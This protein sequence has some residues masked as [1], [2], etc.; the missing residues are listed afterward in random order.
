MGPG[1]SYSR[2]E[3]IFAGIDAPFAFVDLDA[4][5]SNAEFMLARRNGKPIRVAS[6][7][8]RCR[9]ILERILARDEGFA[10]V[11]SFTLPEALFLAEAG[12]RDLLVAY[13]TADRSA[14]GRLASLAAE[15]PDRAPLLTVD[16]SAQL[17][18][19]E[20]AVADGPAAIRVCIDLDLSWRPMGRRAVAIGPKR[21]PIRTPEAAAQLAREIVDR[22]GLRLEGVMAYEGQIA[23]VGDAVPGKPLRNTLTRGMQRA[24]AA[25]IRSRR[26]AMVSAIRKVAEL[27]F[28]NGGGTGS[29]EATAAEDAVSELSAGSGFYAP[30]L[31]DH[32]RSL[33]L[34]PAAVFTLPI[35]RRPDAGVGTAL[36][37]GYVASGAPGRDG[38]PSPYLPEGL[39]LDRHEGAGE[40]QTP[41]V[42]PGAGALRVG[43]RV[44]LRH[45]KAGELCERF[46]SLYLVEGD[47]IVDEVATYRG[48]G[49]AFL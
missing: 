38:L 40:V 14:V 6:N 5:W 9:A 32:Y 44:Y 21:S 20:G 24:S 43:D 26:A 1:D 4:M 22:P 49:K 3:A 27:R 10:G 35:V 23:G 13:P 19:I 34:R 31:F 17:D 48:V 12:H 46:N 41:L 36:G 28:V 18:L 8:V 11:L 15:D 45:A 29:L 16:D 42:G 2:Y 39:K 33:D 37:G 47:E 25:D 30:A 7:A